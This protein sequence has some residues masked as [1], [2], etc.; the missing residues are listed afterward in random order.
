MKTEYFVT[1]ESVKTLVNV[2]E[3]VWIA[4][5]FFSVKVVSIVTALAFMYG[6]RRVKLCSTIGFAPYG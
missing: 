6:V 3:N 1:F 4:F 2:F 5:G